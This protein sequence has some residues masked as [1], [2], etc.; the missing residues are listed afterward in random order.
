MTAERSLVLGGRYLRETLF[1]GDG[2][3]MREA[4]LG[5]DRLDGRYE[6]TTAD[7]F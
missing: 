6:L 7:V 5:Y 3:Q 1:G 2:T 4:V